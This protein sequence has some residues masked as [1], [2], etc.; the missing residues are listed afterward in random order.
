MKNVLVTGGAGFIGSNFIRYL[1]THDRN[2]TVINLDALT[3]AGNLKNLEHLPDEKRHQ[4]IQGDICDD[5]LVNMLFNQYQIDTVI[6]FAAESHV[7]RSIQDPQAFVKTNVNGTVTLLDA[8]KKYWFYHN[9]RSYRFHHISTDEVYGSLNAEDPAFTE[10][11]P[12]LPNSPYAASKAASD[13]FV[14]AYHHTYSLPITMSHCSNNYGP[15]QHIE[16]L[17]PT[18]I[19]NCAEQKSIP[20]YG[21]GSNQRDWLHVEDHC[22]AILKIITDAPNGESYNIGGNNEWNNLTLAKLIC[23]IFD[24]I[25]PKNTSHLELITF[26]KDRLGHDWRYAINNGKMMTQLGWHPTHDF[27]NGIQKTIE[28]YLK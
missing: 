14:R 10:H 22:S 26:V 13:H 3:Y 12:Y 5:R 23:S 4:F 2:V 17:I 16:K 19:K 25:Y 9:N 18:I 15:Y 7:D 24:E 27:L 20:I 8:A 11:S 1:L 6:H 28:F 21:D